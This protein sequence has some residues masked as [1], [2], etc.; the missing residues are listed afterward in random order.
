M[1]MRPDI[2]CLIVGDG[3]LRPELES[4]ARELGCGNVAFLGSRPGAATLM[5]LFDVFCLPSVWEGLGVVLLESMSQ[6]VPIVASRAGAIPEVLDD[7]RCGVLI[8]PSSVSSL[9]GGIDL[10][11]SNPSYRRA[12]VRTAQAHA[13]AAYAVRRMGDE[14]C[15]LYDDLCLK[16]DTSA[17][18][19]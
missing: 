7:G 17:A 2:K 8:D 4:L 11:R 6:G 10:I 16:P 1:A 3:E 9:V 15:R 19:A 13:A 14:T 12:L 5:P 18:A